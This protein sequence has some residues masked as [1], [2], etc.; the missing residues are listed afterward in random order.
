MGC[1]TVL[2]AN[3]S[4]RPP[5]G[6]RRGLRPELLEKDP[7][8]RLLARGPRFRMDSEM[9]RDTVLQ[10]SGLIVNQ[11][12]GPERETVPTAKSVGAVRHQCQRYPSLQTGSRR[13]A[14]PQESLHFL[15]THVHDA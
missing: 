5:T 15:E 14:V 3:C 7:K 4:C 10:A 6:N 12:G 9:I 1:E 8:N 13:R 2:P 11:I